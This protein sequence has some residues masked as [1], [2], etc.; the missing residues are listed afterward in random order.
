M[1]QV[2]CGRKDTPFILAM[3]IV[4]RFLFF[5]LFFLGVFQAFAQEDPPDQF[6]LSK[7]CEY[8]FFR[9]PVIVEASLRLADTELRPLELEFRWHHNPQGQDTFQIA[10]LDGPSLLYVTNGEER[11]VVYSSPQPHI[12]RMALHHLREPVF[13]T[14]LL[15]DDLELLAKGAFQCQD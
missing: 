6:S 9:E 2:P 14:P 13:D 10:R 1:Y 7:F 8:P 4:L 15:Y 3:V 11:W 12:R 5:Y